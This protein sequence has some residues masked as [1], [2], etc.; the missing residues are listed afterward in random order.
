MGVDL[1]MED[2]VQDVTYYDEM[3]GSY[4]F[5]INSEGIL[6]YISVILYR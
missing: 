2:I 1:H 5:I 4:A 3:D 6:F